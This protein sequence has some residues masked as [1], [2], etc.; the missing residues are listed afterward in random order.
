[1]WELVCQF[2]QEINRQLLCVASSSPIYF[3][4]TNLKMQLLYQDF[5]FHRDQENQLISARVPAYKW[6][7]GY[8]VQGAVAKILNTA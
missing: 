2:M 3:N 4:K 7:S 6:G 5:H 1:M 8:G